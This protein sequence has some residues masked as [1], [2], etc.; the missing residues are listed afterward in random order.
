MTGDFRK[1]LCSELEKR[2]AMTTVEIYSLFSGQ[3]PK[4]VAWHLHEELVKGHVAR[5][6]HGIYVLPSGIPKSDERQTNIPDLSRAAYAVLR[7]SGFDFYLSGLD[8]L[9]GLSFSVDGN[10]PVIVCTKRG[11]V[12]DIQLLL[13]RH[14]DLAATEEDFF[15]FDDVAKRRIQF[16][17]LSSDDFS[18]QREDFAFAEKAFVDLYYA[19]TRLEYPLSVSELPHVL[20]LLTPNAYRFRRATKDRGLSDELNFL[21]SYN[22]EFVKGLGEY[23]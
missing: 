11:N 13:M 23:I 18:L 12:K 21:L 15:N 3:N 22:R 9:N 7:E 20:S 17:V 16:L 14:F 6:S 19:V 4:T 1:K 2:G 8:G 10:Y 5:R